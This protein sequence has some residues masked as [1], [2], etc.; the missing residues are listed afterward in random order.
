[1]Q[2]SSRH[3]MKVL[4]LF[5]QR[6]PTIATIGRGVGQCCGTAYVA[7]AAAA[8]AAEPGEEACHELP[9]RAIVCRRANCESCW[10]LVAHGKVA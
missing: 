3:S 1:M 9:Y 8:A 2:I 4:W 6:Q 5:P 10:H 7:K